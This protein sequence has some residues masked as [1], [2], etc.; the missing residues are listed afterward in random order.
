MTTRNPDT[1]YKDFDSVREIKNYRGLRNG[2][3]AD[4]GVYADVVEP[5]R[6]RV[7]DAVEVS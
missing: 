1:G 2:K 7:G 3:H 6:I 4:F 5:G